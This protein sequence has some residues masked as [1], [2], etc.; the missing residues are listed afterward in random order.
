MASFPNKA[1]FIEVATSKKATG[2]LISMGAQ[3]IEAISFLP[4][5]D[6]DVTELRR[7]LRIALGVM[8]AFTIAAYFTN[9]WYEAIALS[10]FPIR[11]FN[12]AIT[13]AALAGCSVVPIRRWRSWA[14]GYF[15]IIVTTSTI[16]ALMVHD[17]EPLFAAML[18]VL[19]DTA[20]V[21]PWGGRRQFSLALMAVA[22][23]GAIACAGLIRTEDIPDWIALE[24]AV[25]LSVSLA[26]LRVYL[27]KQRELIGDLKN[28]EER[29]REENAGRVR[30]EEQLRKE[31][32][33]R[34]AAENLAHK[35]E[36]ILRK[37]LETSLD[38]IIISRLP[39]LRYIY[40]NDQFNASGYT[41]EEARGKTPTDLNIFADTRQSD[42]M[43]ATLY[44][45]GRVTNFE[46]DIRNKN[47]LIVPYLVSAVIA[48]VDG[49]QCMV[50]MSRDITRRKQMEHD[51]IVAREDA[52]A[53][54]RAKSEFLSSMSHE[55]RTPMNAVLGMADLLL[56]TTLN[57]EQRRY[58]DV[59]VAN[60]N[61]LLELIN[62]ILDLAR[63]ESGRLQ[64]EH[65]EFDLTDLID[66][67]I[68][69]F[70]VQ[71]HSKG[72]ELIARIA[73]GVP[74]HL[75]GDPL[76]VRQILIN[77]LGNAIKFTEKG[78]ILLEV[79]PAADSDDP[80]ELCFSVADSGIGIAPGKLKTIFTNFTQADS[81]T[82]RKY[83]GTGLGLA[84]AE[85]LAKLMGGTIT[86]ESEVHQGSKFSVVVRF[87]L[88]T[89]VISPTAH[90]VL[91]LD[92]YR[93][94]VVDDNNI[95][96]LIAREM[97]SNCGAQ[98]SEA[99][100]G[101]EALIAIRQASDQGKPFRIILLDMRM[102]G[103]D[104][105][106]VAQ[107]I[108]EEHLPTEPLI[109]MLSSDDL[110]PQVA[111]LKEL[112]L[113]AYLIKPIT[114]KELFDAIG[115]V[116]QGAN[117][118]SVDALPERGAVS[119]PAQETVP[120]LPLDQP[121]IL[122]ADD[123]ADNRLLIGAYLRREP[124]QLE[125]ADDG[126]IAIEKFK[127][128]QYTMVFMDVQM[129][130]VDGLAATRIIRQW[131]K[132]HHRIATPIIALTASALDEDVQR[133]RAAGCDL[134]LSKPVK[135]SVL[136]DTIRTVLLQLAESRAANDR[137]VLI[138]SA[139]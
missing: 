4:A 81:S 110:K 128:N 48:E 57:G 63:I 95:N 30:A 114:R 84:I 68:S 7:F 92:N 99:A 17:E 53:A 97:I 137:D 78:E 20:I 76:R 19:L 1:D 64:I 82:T 41:F 16:A 54:S 70:G 9:S 49:E 27:A 24:V 73:P 31:I 135:K 83:G 90:V 67:T 113:D 139:S 122:I 2:P 18:V 119:L 33:D 43:I 26:S 105:L 131:E 22:G 134:H 3:L 37:V 25:G 75:I 11:V 65:T 89:R 132:D 12:I 34:E 108:R 38:V 46:L 136:L 106:E 6:A 28:R 109:L 13:L 107:H 112:C 36:A 15:S 138:P 60:G 123:S 74:T 5:R 55:I 133:T 44:E 120:A 42:E 35:R 80:A 115:R 98:V 129:P 21:V 71:A 61:S 69:T 125:F 66:K 62:S 85:R 116:I 103:M 59:M 88:A 124:Y 77:F 91:N 8:L 117:R 58:V 51:L 50:S 100:S 79:T 45:H 86:V 40:V 102:P 104:G 94:L 10:P 32:R 127:S 118:N 126:R 111:R 87:G 39:D 23:F 101:E 93:V 29:L 130:E 96:R 14:V 52:L 56:D 47:G 72:L 121:R